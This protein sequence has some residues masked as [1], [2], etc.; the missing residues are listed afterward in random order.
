MVQY[1]RI[2]LDEMPRA[3]LQALAKSLG[4]KGNLKS[5]VIV[6]KILSL[7]RSDAESDGK[8]DSET[9]APV[10]KAST[11]QKMSKQEQLG[12][13]MKDKLELLSRAEIQEM[14]KRYGLKANLKTSELIKALRMQSSDS[15]S[16]ADESVS[17]D[18]VDQH[19]GIRVLEADLSIETKK[20]K[21]PRRNTVAG[22]LLSVP[23]PT[24]Q[25]SKN[26]LSNDEPISLVS[27]TTEN[28]MSDS[29]QQSDRSSSSRF[30][31]SDPVTLAN[32]P[33][34]SDLTSSTEPISVISDG[35]STQ[36]TD[37]IMLHKDGQQSSTM[38]KK[39]ARSA[40]RN[41]EL[42]AAVGAA[43][44]PRRGG[45]ASIACPRAV[46]EPPPATALPSVSEAALP[47]LSD[48]SDGAGASLFPVEEE[49]APS[50]PSTPP[51]TAA[52]PEP[53]R[54]AS[55]AASTPTAP[56][57]AVAAAFPAGGRRILTRLMNRLTVGRRL[58]H[59]GGDGSSPGDKLS[60]P[61]WSA[62]LQPALDIRF[63]QNGWKEA[64]MCDAR[65]I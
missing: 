63:R 17:S 5:S 40:R 50:A 62:G 32:E 65:K 59:W 23:V 1:T 35:N 33:Q 46:P 37:E 16:H 4:L 9:Q 6:E 45:R 44:A 20:S 13:G 24:I 11:N 25:E 15:T 52:L 27:M 18:Q 21:L 36:R 41:T 19:G 22:N 58:S 26:T 42:G 55:A 10:S 31:K 57:G 56:P 30:K 53:V 8:S 51:T 38:P 12:S 39:A 47:S 7:S 28:S 43:A 3:E 54:S 49:S 14:A 60:P 64:S 48:P 29:R 61:R 34:Q 2:Q